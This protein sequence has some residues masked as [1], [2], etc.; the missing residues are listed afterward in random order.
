MVCKASKGRAHQAAPSEE[1]YLMVLSHMLQ[2]PRFFAVAQDD[3]WEAV[4]IVCNAD[5]IL[6]A[7]GDITTLGP[8][9]GQTSEPFLVL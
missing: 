9:A 8:K 1:W 6:I 7:E 4:R 2:V 5:Y 3:E